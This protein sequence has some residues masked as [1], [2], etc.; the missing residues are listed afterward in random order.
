MIVIDRIEDRFAIA[1]TKN[2]TLSI[3]LDTLPKQVREGDV[4]Y[5]TDSGYR[6]DREQTEQRR[7]AAAAILRRI[8]HE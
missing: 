1:E 5:M 3:P 8:T 2:G 7:S 6:I 4:L